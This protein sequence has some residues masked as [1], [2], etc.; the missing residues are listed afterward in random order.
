MSNATQLIWLVL[1]AIMVATVLTVG[2]L[3]AA[4]LLPKRRKKNLRELDAES[5]DVTSPNASQA[6]PR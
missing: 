5:P 2:T 1:A 6:P 3:G 4:D